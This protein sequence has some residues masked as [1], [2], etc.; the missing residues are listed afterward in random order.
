MTVLDW[1]FLIVVLGCVQTIA[2]RIKRILAGLA[3]K[4]QEESL[5]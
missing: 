4:Q 5:P 1:T 3:A 2:V